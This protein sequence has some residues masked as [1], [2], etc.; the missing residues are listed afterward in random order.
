VD[1][2]G[3]TSRYP[4]EARVTFDGIE[5]HL[6]HQVDPLLARVDR[7][8]WDGT[9]PQVLIY[10]HSH[11]G[12]AHHHGDTLLFNPGSAGPRRFRLIPSVGILTLDNNRISTQ[13]LALE[14]HEQEALNAPV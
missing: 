10:G 13:L 12:A 2:F 3:A 11:R 9:A 14:T 7:N 6:V 1:A 5:I 8:G 4:E